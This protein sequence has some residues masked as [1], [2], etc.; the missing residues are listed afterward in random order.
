MVATIGDRRPWV[1]ARTVP[2]TQEALP[3][4]FLIY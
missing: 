1:N 4:H 3:E 2:G